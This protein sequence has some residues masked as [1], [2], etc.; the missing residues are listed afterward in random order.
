MKAF[1]YYQL[2]ACTLEAFEVD[3]YTVKSITNK[4]DCQQEVQSFDQKQFT[5]A[6]TFDE[7]ELLKY[8]NNQH[9]CS[10]AVQMTQVSH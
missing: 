3:T 2:L 7:S 4:T 9:V 5:L 6:N 10:R 8:T 1:Y